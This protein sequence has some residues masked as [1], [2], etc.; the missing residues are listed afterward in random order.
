MKRTKLGSAARPMRPISD[1]FDGKHFFNPT[2]PKGYVPRISS[3]FK[4]LSEK[5]SSWPKTA[6]NLGTPRMHEELGPGDVAI[7]FIGHV[8][9]LIQMPGIN[10]L[11]DPIWSKR[12]SPFRRIGPRRVRS[13]AVAFD[14][15]PPIDLILIS[16]N[17]Y[18]HLDLKTLKR[19]QERFAPKALIAAGDK[20]LVQSTGLTD[21]HEFDWWDELQ[22]RPGLKVTFAPT[23][24]FSARS[25]WN[26]QKSL[27]GGFMIE[28]EGRRV[29]FCGDAGYSSHFVDI[30][31]RLGA[32]DIALFGI[33][34]Y[35]PR[36]FM[37]SMHMNPAEAVQAHEDIG[38]KQSIAMHFGTFRMSAEGIDQPKDELRIALS[39]KGIS[40]DSFAVLKEG[41]TRI[42]RA[43]KK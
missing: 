41:E 23:Q 10:I 38:S 31:K 5:K 35:E 37:R 24:H 26:R 40:E 36:W 29:F 30:K 39:Q 6:K 34:S 17:H 33:G 21:V 4:M 1:H 18:D 28:N 11:T 14:D 7:T 32:P 12:A 27:W 19:L 42:F 3:V 25:L 2:L 13:P 15:L 8:T 9:F 22:L 16:H 43:D 20:R